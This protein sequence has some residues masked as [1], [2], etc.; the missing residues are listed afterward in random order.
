MPISQDYN[1]VDAL[2]LSTTNFS[3]EKNLSSYTVLCKL[4]SRL[5]TN[6]GNYVQLTLFGPKDGC[7]V[8]NVTISNT[9]SSGN[10]YNADTTPTAITWND[11]SSSVSLFNGDRLVSD[12]VAFKFEITPKL[13]GF[14]ISTTSYVP[15]S[16]YEEAI[17]YYLTAVQQADD[18]TRS[19]GYTAV[20]NTIPFL[21]GLQ[22][23]Q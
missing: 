14:N 23:S 2:D 8:N 12:P 6:V 20:S 17:T 4:P 5:F 13:I 3:V 18:T 1:W 16:Y 10:A 22:V 11:G 21:I 15:F 19:T 7:V 9:A